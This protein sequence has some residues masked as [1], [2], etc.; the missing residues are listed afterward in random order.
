M[1]RPLFSMVKS[2]IGGFCGER[3]DSEERLRENNFLVSKV[4]DVKVIA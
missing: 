4:K 2:S 3:G 1:R